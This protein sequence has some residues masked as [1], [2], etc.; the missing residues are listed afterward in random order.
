M[1]GEIDQAVWSGGYLRVDPAGG[2]GEEIVGRETIDED[3][4]RAVSA[5][6]SAAEID[7]FESLDGKKVARDP[8]GGS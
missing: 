3:G 8:S 7:E 1:L 4:V 5:Y 2:R 6:Y